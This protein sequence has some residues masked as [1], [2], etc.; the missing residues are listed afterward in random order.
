MPGE[1]PAKTLE[2]PNFPIRSSNVQ[3]GMRSAIKPL[4]VSLPVII[5]EILADHAPQMFLSQKNHS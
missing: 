5:L 2:P 1:H 3:C 4:L